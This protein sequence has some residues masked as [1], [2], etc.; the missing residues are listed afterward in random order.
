M[1]QLRSI[2]K[3][4]RFIWSIENVP[5][6]G[7][8]LQ[9]QCDACLRWCPVQSY[10]PSP[11]DNWDL[12]QQQLQACVGFNWMDLFVFPIQDSGPEQFL[13]PTVSFFKT[14]A[15]DPASNFQLHPV[16]CATPETL[17]RRMFNKHNDNH[18]ARE[19]SAVASDPL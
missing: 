8:R 9:C 3:K 13:R 18:L 5:R 14:Q 1:I 2:I 16:G 10:L 12:F 6:G 4:I 15:M 7:V 19:K 17:R 11:K